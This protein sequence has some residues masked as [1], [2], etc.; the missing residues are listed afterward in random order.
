LSCLLIQQLFFIRVSNLSLLWTVGRLILPRTVGPF[1]NLLSVSRLHP[2]FYH[3]RPSSFH[4]NQQIHSTHSRIFFIPRWATHHHVQCYHLWV[5]RSTAMAGGLLFRTS[6]C[7]RARIKQSKIET[8]V[9]QP[10]NI[11]H[12]AEN[13]RVITWRTSMGSR[14]S[15]K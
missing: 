7:W 15:L 6:E 8:P 1:V 14:T 5:S 2:L 12:A 9:V 10:I 13:I 11:E 3:G 4:N